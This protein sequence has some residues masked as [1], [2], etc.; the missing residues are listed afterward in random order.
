MV[1]VLVVDD[2]IDSAES[3]AMLLKLW[4]HE[5]RTAYE[6]RSALTMARGGWPDVVLLDIGLPEMDGNE[7]ARR[8]REEHGPARPRLVAV[9]GYG[10]QEDRLRS[11]QAGFDHHIVKPVDPEELLAALNPAP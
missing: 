5:V 3:L 8:L 6:G 1:R 10:Q 7:V 9:T 4:G 11:R 2:N